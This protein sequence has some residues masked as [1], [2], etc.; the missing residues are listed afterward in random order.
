MH[1][2]QR[3]L[4]AQRREVVARNDHPLNPLGL[5]AFGQGQSPLRVT[6]KTFEDLV[7]GAVVGEVRVREGRTDAPAVAGADHDEPVRFFNRQLSE[8]D[9]INQTEDGCVGADTNG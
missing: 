6:D 1:N 9:L 8:H 3:W 5:A 7:P 4:D 2:D